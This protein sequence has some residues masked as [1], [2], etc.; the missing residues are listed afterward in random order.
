VLEPIAGSSSDLPGT[1]PA[2]PH[3]IRF[4]VDGTHLLVS[5]EGNNQIDVFAL[6]TTGLV[7]DVMSTPA[8]GSGPFG[9]RF[10]REGV[11]VNTEANSGSV[12][13]YTLASNDLL[14]VISPAVAST[15]AAT[16]WITLTADGKFWV[17][18]QYW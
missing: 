10:G 1:N 9:E 4:T 17:R 6:N 2:K 14:E 8:A 12:S 7:T 3:D 11:L 16:C 18:F 5:D 13:T 15:Q